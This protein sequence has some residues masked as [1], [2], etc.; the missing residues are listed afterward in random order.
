LAQSA[1]LPVP[2]WFHTHREA[3]LETPSDR[4]EG[5]GL[6]GGEAIER[7]R[8]AVAQLA[9]AGH[10]GDAAAPDRYAEAAEIL[11]HYYR[12]AG[13][14]ADARAALRE[15][16]TVLE[17]RPDATRQVRVLDVLGLLAA[18][19]AD[20]GE[21][22]D[23]WT[24]AVAVHR[25]RLGADG[26]DAGLARA[27]LRLGQWHVAEQQWDEAVTHLDEA[28]AHFERDPEAR[29][30][31]ELVEALNLLGTAYSFTARPADAVVA[32]ERALPLARARRAQDSST[33]FRVYTAQLMNGLGRFNLDLGRPAEAC[34]VLEECLAECRAFVA[35]APAP[36]LRTLLSAVLYRL[37]QCH[38]AL[39]DH[40]AAEALLT[41]SIGLMRALVDGEG[42]GDLAEDLAMVED[43]LHRLHT[44]GHDEN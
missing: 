19:S 5:E 9:A 39:G 7:Q 21:A 36:G 13:N 17:T 12:A 20:V 42:R 34:A 37:G 38:V 25:A 4:G 32:L 40:A 31:H 6:A 8:Q 29:Q 1:D 2:G 3:P 11:A 27:V 16:L 28:I 44:A 41:E 14:L 26:S 23:L 35:D 24:T 33:G 15:V 22:R 18:Q 10:R 30:S 43:E